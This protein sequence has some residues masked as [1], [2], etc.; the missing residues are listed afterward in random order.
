MFVTDL[1]VI[2]LARGQAQNAA[3]AGALAGAIARGFD[4]FTDPPSVDGAAFQS[5][6]G[7][8]AGNQVVGLNA[9]ADVSW[10]CPAWL[11]AATPPRCTQVDVYRD[12]T[13]GSTLLP[14]FFSAVFPG[15]PAAMKVRAT[16]TARVRNANTSSCLKPWLIPDLWNEVT[17]PSDQFNGSDT[18]TAPGYTLA[19]VG[20]PA[21]TM[22]LRPGNPQQA[23]A[24]SNYYGIGSATD[25]EDHIVNC[26][27]TQGLNSVVTTLPG[28]HNG[29]TQHGVEDLLANGPVI[30]TVGLFSPVEFAALD[31]QTGVYDIHVVNIMG[32]RITD[33]APNGSIYGEIVA[34]PGEFDD[35]LPEPSGPG[36][37]LKE[38]R[39]IR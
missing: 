17:P 18:Y 39:L 15:G 1:G 11:V 33:V 13:H 8:A 7:A 22:I 30:V 19:V 31:R 3:D 26:D 5:A 20:T 9:V 37:F 21:A 29:P 2:W 25:Y 6:H 4:E 14:A 23:T 38:I 28:N 36:A 12:N 27:L 32:F 34:A 35:A 24:P 10:N 16:A